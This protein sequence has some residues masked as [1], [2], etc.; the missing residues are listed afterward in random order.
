[1]LCLRLAMARSIEQRGHHETC[2]LIG[3]SRKLAAYT[4]RAAERFST[5]LEYELVDTNR[6]IQKVGIE[7]ATRSAVATC[8]IKEKAC[9]GKFGPPQI[10]SPRNL[11]AENL[12]PPELFCT[13]N[14]DP[15][16]KIWTPMSL[17]QF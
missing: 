5:T 12:F 15:P 1:M 9:H 14:L 7:P 6:G 2:A 8:N 17:G 3:T 13:E 16:D 10:S 4:I 11:F